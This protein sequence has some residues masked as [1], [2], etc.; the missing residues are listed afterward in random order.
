MAVYLSRDV[1]P[2]PMGQ[3]SLDNRKEGRRE[4][5]RCERRAAG[6]A[7]YGIP[8]D[9]LNVVAAECYATAFLRFI[10]GQCRECAAHLERP[11][12]LA[13]GSNDGADLLASYA[14]LSSVHLIS[15]GRCGCTGSP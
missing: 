6:W 4:R 1:I 7:R 14:A 3:T 15:L 5:A 9:N 8:A 12:N 10:Q 11:G 2:S 13:L